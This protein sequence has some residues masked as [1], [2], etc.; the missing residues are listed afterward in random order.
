ML[1]VFGVGG[2]G[3]CF[4]GV[5]GWGFIGCVLFGSWVEG[6]QAGIRFEVEEGRGEVSGRG[7]E[8][9]MEKV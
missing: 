5:E 6:L 1:C 8:G 2:G 7:E 4:L 9:S 3:S